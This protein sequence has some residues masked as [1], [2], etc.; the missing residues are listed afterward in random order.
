MFK[1]FVLIFYLIFLRFFYETK[2][3]NI[4]NINIA[5]VFSAIFDQFN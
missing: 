1:T 4:W 5:N 2:V 3:Q